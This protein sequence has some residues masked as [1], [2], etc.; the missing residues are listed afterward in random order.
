M[1][2]MELYRIENDYKNHKRRLQSIQQLSSKDKVAKVTSQQ[3]YMA[4]EHKKIKIN[5]EIF[6]ERQELSR[7]EHSN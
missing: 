1:R 5:S 4:N 2:I 3:F 6:H 7:R